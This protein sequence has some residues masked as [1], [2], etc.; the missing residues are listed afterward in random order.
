MAKAFLDVSMSG[1]KTAVAPAAPAP[2]SMS[3][4]V[5]FELSFFVFFRFFGI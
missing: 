1:P 2:L 5:M 4:R 3:L